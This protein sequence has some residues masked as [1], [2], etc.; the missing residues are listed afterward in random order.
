MQEAEIFDSKNEFYWIL[1]D[2]ENCDFISAFHIFF[3]RDARYVYLQTYFF[4]FFDNSHH[5]VG[6]FIFLYDI[7]ILLNQ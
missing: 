5:S 3:L 6:L 4:F 7:Q 1:K 2:S